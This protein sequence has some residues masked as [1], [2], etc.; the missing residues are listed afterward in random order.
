MSRESGS[1]SFHKRRAISL[2]PCAR[3][4]GGLIYSDRKGDELGK[5]ATRSRMRLD[6]IEYLPA[7]YSCTAVWLKKKKGGVQCIRGYSYTCIKMYRRFR[8]YNSELGSY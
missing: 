3:L 4:G 2:R 6:A 8:G 7:I 5:R 1:G